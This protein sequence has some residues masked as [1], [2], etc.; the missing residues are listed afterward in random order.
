MEILKLLLL[1]PILFTKKIINNI[2]HKNEIHL[3]GIYGYFGLCGQGKTISMTYQLDRL[4]KKYGDKI[5]IT[6]N[7]GY[8]QED[9]P[10][11][12]WK[13]LCK[14][15]DKPLIVAWDEVQNEFCAREFKNFPINLLTVLTQNRKGY[16]VQIHYTSQRFSFVDKA[17]RELTNVCYNCRTYFENYTIC[18][19]YDFK[20]FEM[21]NNLEKMPPKICSFSFI[22]NNK[23]YSKYDTL[24]YLESAKKRVY[25][26]GFIIDE[27]Q[28]TQTHITIVTD[29]KA[30]K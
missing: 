2:K 3:W 12:D 17:F 21:L 16:G 27:K 6:T 13:L 23:L 28:P 19:G 22:H 14:R 26:Q 11:T 20:Y 25:T 4:R 10:F 18:N 7:Y 24:K 9:F 1:S 5:L 8:V 30:K 15:Y 29:K